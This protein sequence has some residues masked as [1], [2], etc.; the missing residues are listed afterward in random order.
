MSRMYLAMLQEWCA[1][2]F[3]RVWGRGVMR[4]GMVTGL[5]L[6]VLVGGLGFAI[7]E[8]GRGNIRRL[9]AKIETNRTIVAVA[10]PGGQESIELTRMRLMGGTMPEFLSVTMLPGR[11]MNVL[12]IGAYIPG[13][14]EV[15]LLASPS[16]EG[17]ES[18]MTGAGEDADG[19][20]S[21]TMGGAF[22][23]PWAGR[24]GGVASQV[25]GRVSAMWRG[26][27]MTLPGGTQGVAHDGL[28]LANAADSADTTSLPDGGQA[29]AVFHAGDFGVHWPSKTDV[30]VTVLLGSQWIEL[31]VVA[32]NTGDAPEP[33]GIG[34]HPRFIIFDGNR[35]QLRLRLPGEMREEVRDR[36]SGLP[37]GVLLAV[38]GT[39][40]DF[41]GRGGAALGK[42]DLDD[43]FVALHRDLMDNSA[44]AELS[45]PANDYGVR[46]TALSPTIKAF[47]VIAPADGNYVSIGPQFNYDD[48]FGR[49]WAKGADTGMVVLQPGQSTQWEVRLEL[50]SLAG[51]Q[52]AK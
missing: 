9:K 32:R 47:R 11:G 7:R 14:G 28:L 31:T 39:P 43:S 17:A 34:W 37:T 13:K 41:T 2:Q 44:V 51:N 26:R 25:A 15:N 48:P 38:N 45:D 8:R 52:N 46:L 1:L 27:T 12:Q 10:L 50:Y 4:S 3:H 16:V 23:A 24:I 19:K 30:T 21:L 6:A 22:E 29:Q 18:A 49:E 36:E 40:Y 42:M 20:A 5:I 35:E 33:V